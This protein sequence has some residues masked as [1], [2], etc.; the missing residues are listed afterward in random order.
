MES[1]FQPLA[2]VDGLVAALAQFR[3]GMPETEFGLLVAQWDQVRFDCSVVADCTPQE[4]SD[5]L[6]VLEG[7]RRSL[8]AA[9]AVLAGRLNAGRDTRAKL[10]RKTGMSSKQANEIV[11]VVKVFG[12]LPGSEELLSAGKVS[13]AQLRPLAHINTELAASV[14]PDAEGMGA[15]QFVT[16]VKKRNAKLNAKSLTEEQ[17]A[18]RSVTFFETKNGCVGARI[19]LPP[20]D[21]TELR[22]TLNQLCDA[23]YRK[24]HPERATEV[25]G[26]DVEP[27]ERRLA[28][29]FRV[30]MRDRNVGAG[31]P[32]VIVTVDAETLDA[33][34]VPNQ[35]ISLSTAAELA[36]RGDLY[37]AIRK[38]TQR[39]Q[40]VFGRNRRLASPLQRLALMC[41]QHTCVW[42]GC[43]E[44]ATR[45]EVD[46]QT[47]FDAGGHT[48]IR[49]L[50]FLCP[51]HHR[52]RHLQHV[53]VYEHADGTWKLKPPKPKPRRAA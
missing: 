21:G 42:E 7:V 34:I 18:S 38:G 12:S 20:A 29:T 23:H 13:V 11:E 22:E 15:D 25:G 9:T 24:D 6:V 4:A 27:R 40:L 43:N 44:S 50:R 33:K 16:F 5:G 46:H 53:D 1:G 35:P 32:A 51:K 31:R 39:A 36:A 45:C 30:W 41:I 17:E 26:H 14:L 49:N 2:V 48:D 37:A 8:D 19:V 10:V 47:D 3:A 52:H 28:D